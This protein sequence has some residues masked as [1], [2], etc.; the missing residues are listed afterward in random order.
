MLHPV[1]N[2]GWQ[3]QHIRPAAKTQGRLSPIHSHKPKLETTKYFGLGTAASTTSWQC[4][5][6]NW[7]PQ[8]VGTYIATSPKT[9]HGNPLRRHTYRYFNLERESKTPGGSAVSSFCC[10][11]LGCIVL[12]GGKSKETV[13]RGGINFFGDVSGC[14]ESELQPGVRFCRIMKKANLPFDLLRDFTCAVHEKVRVFSA[15]HISDSR[16]TRSTFPRYTKKATIR[17]HPAKNW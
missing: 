11:L 9:C 14:D 17:S 16:R 4:W 3:H 1:H 2:R 7:T 8:L 10:N 15:R 12:G 6:V 13:R 5:C